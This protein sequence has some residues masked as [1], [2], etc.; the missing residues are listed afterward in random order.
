MTRDG[1]SRPG[2]IGGRLAKY[3]TIRRAVG[4][5]VMGVWS[6]RLGQNGCVTC[7]GLVMGKGGVG[8][9]AK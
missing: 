7:M 9:R 1:I 6:M 8:M 4:A 3:S 5:W 2:H